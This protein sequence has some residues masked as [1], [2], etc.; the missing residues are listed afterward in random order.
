MTEQS[1][2]HGISFASEDCVQ[3]PEAAHS[4]DVIQDTVNLEGR[5]KSF[6]NV[7]DYPLYSSPGIRGLLTDIRDFSAG[8][9]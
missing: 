9:R 3:Y 6:G 8:E 7:S 2:S 1:Q 5:A 4:G